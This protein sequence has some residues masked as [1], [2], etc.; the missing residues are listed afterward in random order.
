MFEFRFA[1]YIN[2]RSGPN[3]VTVWADSFALAE[4]Q[5]QTLLGTIHIRHYL[6]AQ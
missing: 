6:P 3:A 4:E 5:A 2:R 1:R